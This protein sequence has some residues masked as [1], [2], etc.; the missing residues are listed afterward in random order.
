MS[1]QFVS[2]LTRVC[3][4]LS[5]PYLSKLGFLQYSS[6]PFNN[7]NSSIYYPKAILNWKLQHDVLS[8]ENSQEKES[9]RSKAYPRSSCILHHNGFDE[10]WEG[11]ILKTS[12]LAPHTPLVSGYSLKEKT[13]WKSL[14]WKL[15]ATTKPIELQVYRK[16][17]QKLQEVNVGLHKLSFPADKQKKWMIHFT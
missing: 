14:T 5:F 11:K 7:L 12:V 4:L 15:K 13:E 16:K 17:S 3:L 10:I 6:R 1:S 2:M 8:K 9:S